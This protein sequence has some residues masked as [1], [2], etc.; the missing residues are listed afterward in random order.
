MLTQ[1]DQLT[2]NLLGLEILGS[3]TAIIGLI[4]FI[5]A[6]ITGKDILLSSYYNQGNFRPNLNPDLQPLSVVFIYLLRH[7]LLQEQLP[8]V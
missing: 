8:Y 7:L 3:V 5:L 2:L 4:L 1:D 6:S